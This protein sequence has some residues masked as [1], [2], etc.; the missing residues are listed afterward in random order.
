MGLQP[1]M[2]DSNIRPS[3]N[4]EGL[5]KGKSQSSV[6]TSGISRHANKSTSCANL[7]SK[8]KLN[9]MINL[10]T[11]EMTRESV[12]KSSMSTKWAQKFKQYKIPQR[13]KSRT[14]RNNFRDKSQTSASA[15]RKS[16]GAMSNLSNI[17]VNLG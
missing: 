15:L 4:D 12:E 10:N 13:G 7:G 17:E 16:D 8:L 11:L 1:V 2:R 3:R 9:S 14:S 5:S 6:Q